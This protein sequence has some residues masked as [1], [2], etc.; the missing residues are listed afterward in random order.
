MAG[1]LIHAATGRI[2][3]RRR[4]AHRSTVNSLK[5]EKRFQFGPTQTTWQWC[6]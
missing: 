4:T 2:R 3:R 5:G 1:M 6:W